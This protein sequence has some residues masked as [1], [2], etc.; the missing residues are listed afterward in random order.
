MVGAGNRGRGAEQDGFK[1]L[2][3]AGDWWE[4]GWLTGKVKPDSFASGL[5]G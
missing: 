4:M 1:D 2:G 5:N 3:G